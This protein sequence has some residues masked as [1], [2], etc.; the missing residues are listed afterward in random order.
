MSDT[1]E[2][3]FPTG[4]EVSN[5]LSRDME[6]E[7][8]NQDLLTA[9]LPNGFWIE[10][11]WF[12]ENDING[13]FVVRVIRDHETISERQY[14]DFNSLVLAVQRL[15]DHYSP[16]TVF[17]SRSAATELTSATVNLN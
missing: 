17:I 12:P 14:K 6:P 11:G 15:I 4:S 2:F 3:Q 9:R 7:E 16:G 13:A 1:V 10:V 8:L 5:Y